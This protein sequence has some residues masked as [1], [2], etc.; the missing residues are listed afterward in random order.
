MFKGNWQLKTPNE[1]KPSFFQ[2][3]DVFNPNLSHYLN[4]SCYK[5]MLVHELRIFFLKTTMAFVTNRIQGHHRPYTN[6]QNS[7]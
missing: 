6:I 4:T 2:A 3:T 1:N 5:L 7:F